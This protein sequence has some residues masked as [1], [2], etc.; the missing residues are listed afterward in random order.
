M[1]N[2]FGGPGFT[3][4]PVTDDDIPSVL[5]VYRRCEDFLALGPVP[6]TSLEMVTTD[7]AHSKEVGGFYCGIRDD[8]DEIVGVLDFIPKYKRGRAFLSLLMIASAHRRRG[9]GTALLA[10]LESHLMLTAGAKVIESGVQVNNEAGISFWKKRGFRIGRRARHMADG[11]TA[12]QM[13]K[14]IEMPIP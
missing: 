12:Y 14:H 5:E 9:L 7:I 11:T 8:T 13:S 2:L 10:A 6:C 3:V 4:R 1:N